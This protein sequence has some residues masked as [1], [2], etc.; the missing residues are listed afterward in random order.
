MSRRLDVLV[1]AP[2]AV[3]GGQEEWL[4]QLLVATDRLQ[5]RALLLQDGPLRDRLSALG[6][7]VDVLEVGNRPVDLVR[8]VLALAR[9]LRRQR[10]DVV[11]ANG[12][13]A[14]FV[15]APAAWLAGVPLVFARH[16]HA[17]E[18]A[19][20]RLARAAEVVVGPSP[21]VLVATGRD[22][23]VVI[24]PALP[25]PALSRDGAWAALVEAGLSRPVGPVL[26][27]LTRLV[28]YKGVDD[29]I[30]ALSL[31]GG[32]RWQL[33]VLGGD[34]PADPGERTRLEALAAAAGVSDRVQ[35]G[36]YL[37]GASRLV[38]AFDALAVLTK[39]GRAGDPLGE[40]FGMT[41][42]EAMAA[43]VP[44]M[45]TGGGPVARRLAGRAGEVVDAAAPLQIAA[46]LGRLAEPAV[47][48]AASAA[49]RELVATHPSA[50]A[51]A[52]RLAG[53]LSAAARRPGAAR[54]AR[55]PPVS[56]VVPVFNEEQTVEALV[57]QLRAQLGPDDELVVID[58]ASGDRTGAF[59]AALAGQEPRLTVHAL[60]TNG[61]ASA[62]RNAGI[63][64]ARHP[65]LVCTD[66]G[67]DLPPG[68]L[69]G[70]RTALADDPAPDLVMGAYEVTRDTPVEAAM[71]VALYPDLADTRHPGPVARWYARLFGRS[72]DATRPAGRS[73]AFRRTAWERVGGFPEHLRAGEDIA[74]GRAIAESGGRCVLQADSPVVWK[75]HATLTGT[76]RMYRSY[77]RGDGLYGERVVVARNAVRG[78]AAAVA[79]LLVLAGGSRSR[80]AVALGAAAYLSLPVTKALREPQPARTAALVPVVLAVKDLAKAYGCLLGVLERRRSAR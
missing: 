74:F 72:F 57:Q 78:A 53:V 22:D 67:N 79:P 41:A 13:K 31:P 24:E 64:L 65:L 44:V 58:D 66:A 25:P 28:G 70:M 77:G 23:A 55:Q 9:Q 14:Q 45:T 62:A 17:F 27:M 59:L 21:E 61:G 20:R 4:L 37:A 19:V 5:V 80:A 7:P 71:A 36:G 32:Q 47:H 40:G 42:L 29:A 30:T 50:H 48:A 2:H 43:G 15:A 68:W 38:G 49:C 73:V 39:P 76:A 8:P 51:S 3:V 63:T 18:G 1:I 46:A 10:P 35:L 54:D 75:H 56:V 6:I 11:L 26:A 52:D 69:S 34:D 60:A 12:V 33:V 16:D